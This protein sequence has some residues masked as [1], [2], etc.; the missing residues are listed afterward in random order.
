MYWTFVY[1]IAVNLVL[2]EPL[3][4]IAN[5]YISCIHWYPRP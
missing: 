3:Y 5:V 4:S 1:P 2:K